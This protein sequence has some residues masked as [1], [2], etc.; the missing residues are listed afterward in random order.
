MNKWAHEK[1]KL[2]LTIILENKYINNRIPYTETTIIGKDNSLSDLHIFSILWYSIL[3]H[4]T[5]INATTVQIMHKNIN[6]Q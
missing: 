4:K 6:R 2:Y 5:V 1:L 3:N